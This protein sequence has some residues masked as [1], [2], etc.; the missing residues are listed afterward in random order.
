MYSIHCYLF[1]IESNLEGNTNGIKLKNL[2]E[3]LNDITTSVDPNDEMVGSGV[4]NIDDGISCLQ[5]DD[6]DS[7]VEEVGL[8]RT[9]KQSEVRQVVSENNLSVCAIL[10]SHVELSMLSSICYKVFR[11]WDWTSNASICAKGCRIILEWN[12]DVVD[13]MVVAQ[14]NQ[15][16][17]AKVFHKADNHIIFCSFVYERNKP[18]EHR[19]LWADLDKHKLVAR[20]F[21]WV[22]M[23]DFN[24]ALNIEDSHLGSS[25]MTS[26]MKSSR[27]IIAKLVMA[28]SA[29]FIWQERNGRLFKKSKKSVNQIIKV[30]F[31]SVR[32]KLLSC[33]FKRSKDG[34]FFAQLWRLPETCFGR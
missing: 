15:A 14:S 5:N 22:L 26:D 8:N 27:S 3:K 11:S 7:K 21:P 6:S 1:F 19:V 24:V 2:F 9:P 23:G 17:H 16:I 31:S 34:V 13:V 18:K 29:Y 10:E 32:L 25:L 28:A 12:K 33:R 20:G 4:S 30:I